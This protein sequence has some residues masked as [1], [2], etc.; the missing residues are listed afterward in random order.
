MEMEILQRKPLT[1]KISL[2]T[3]TRPTPVRL[4]LRRRSHRVLCP[5]TRVR[6]ARVQTGPHF[7]LHRPRTVRDRTCDPQAGRD[8][9]ECTSKE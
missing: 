7:P 2:Y 8:R 6:H 9:G 3:V 4:F 5:L 1:I